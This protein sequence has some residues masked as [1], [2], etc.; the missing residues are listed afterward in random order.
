MRADDPNELA[1]SGPSAREAPELAME[2]LARY[3]SRRPL[4]GVGVTDL[5]DPRPAY[6]RVV[7]PL[8]ATPEQF[9]RLRAGQGLHETL[10]RRLGPVATREFRVR[11]DGI[12]GRIDVLDGRPIELKSTDSPPREGEDLR[13]SR[14]SYL[15]QLAM[16]A[17]LV[18]RPDGRLV[19]VRAGAHAPNEVAVW[20]LTLRDPSAVRIEMTRRATALRDARDRHDPKGLPRC[21]WFDRGCPYRRE[22]ACD[23]SGDEVPLSPAI[24]E[25]VESP[26]RNPVEGMRIGAL[27]DQPGLPATEVAR[28]GEL[29]YPRRAFFDATTEAAAP[30]EKFK[31]G[32]PAE[33]WG[34]LHAVLEDGPPG[35]YELRYPMSGTPEEA[36]ECFRSEPV[37]VKSTRALRPVAATALP[38]ERPHYVLELALRCGSLGASAGWL[39]LGLERVPSEGD[40]IRAQRVEFRDPSYLTDL[41]ARRAA[42]LTEAR[43][44]GDGAGL[45]AC[46]VW[47][48]DGCPHRAVCGCGTPVKAGGE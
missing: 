25:A 43:R 28:F 38:T 8:P 47:M 18:D 5:I 46:P 6:W 23:C 17:A 19:I 32:E 13:E 1:P 45:P 3:R 42:E 9:A 36:V 48:F 16:Y 22:T 20:D 31:S 10:G 4:R 14:P 34:A 26:R 39:I 21:A 2:L 24:L 29:A 27:L 37:L 30:A 33:T 40:W 11:R 12:V 7:A 15:E 41:V 44:H 35:E